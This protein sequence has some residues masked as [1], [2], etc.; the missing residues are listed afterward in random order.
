MSEGVCANGDESIRYANSPNAAARGSRKLIQ[1][2]SLLGATERTKCMLTSSSVPNTH[3]KSCSTRC[4]TFL[5][6]NTHSQ[7]GDPE[8]G[9]VRDECPSRQPY[10]PFHV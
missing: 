8:E 4:H 1:Y 9:Y 7:L 2:I 3:P 10:D 6:V 5:T